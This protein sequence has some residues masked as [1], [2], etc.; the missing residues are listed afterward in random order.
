MASQQVDVDYWQ[1]GK[2]AAEA[3]YLAANVA[4]LA[5]A[6]SAVL[7]PLGWGTVYGIALLI[8]APDPVYYPSGL[9]T[10]KKLDFERG[11]KEAAMMKRRRLVNIGGAI[12][13][14]IFVIL[15]FT[16][17]QAAIGTGIGLGG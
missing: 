8:D 11:Y 1:L 10:Q 15:F 2:A 6:S 3:E 13:T 5:F 12:G 14:A 9:T 17:Q 4:A 16:L 7:G